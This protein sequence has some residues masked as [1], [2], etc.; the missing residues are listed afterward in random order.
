MPYGRVLSS[1]PPMVQPSQTRRYAFGICR[2][3][4]KL[5]RSSS[6]HPVRAERS[7]YCIYAFGSTTSLDQ[8]RKN[9]DLRGNTYD[10]N[11]NRAAAISSVHQVDDYSRSEVTMAILS[12]P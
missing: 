5:G 3:D 6:W 9:P 8:G 11:G 1:D 10:L 7:K 2:E 12:T 4:V